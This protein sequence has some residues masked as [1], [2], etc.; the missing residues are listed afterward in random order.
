MRLPIGES[1]FRKIIDGKF[2]FVDKSLLIPEIIGGAEVILITRPRRFGKTL[3]MSMLR[4]FFAETV[5]GKATKGLFDNLKVMQSGEEVLKHKGQYPVIFLSFRDIKEASFESAYQKIYETIIDLYNEFSYLQESPSL[6]KQ[7]K[8]SFISI[9]ERDANQAQLERSLKVLTDFLYQHHG[10]SPIVLIDEYDTPIQ[11]GFLNGYYDEV[12]RFFRGFL[13]AALKDNPSLSKAV[14]SGIMRVSRESLFSGL[15]NVKV[16][17][18]LHP[19]FSSFFG[20]TQDEIDQLLLKAG[21]QGKTAD[22]KHWYNGYQIG[23]SVLYN[24]WSI[25]NCIQDKGKL[26]PFWV[27]TSDNELLKDLLL[28]SSAD[29]KAE[30]ETLLEGTPVELIVDEH[31]VFPDLKKNREAAVWS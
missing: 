27:N 16:Y 11:S 15:N 2:D 23:D 14:M 17:S 6:S 4:Y 9:L 30:F 3:N 25:V 31:F 29:F 10:V 1:D 28:A 26:Q 12:I 21:L 13:S 18:I 24:P 7:Q 22:V 8:D 20:F 5:R 19:Q